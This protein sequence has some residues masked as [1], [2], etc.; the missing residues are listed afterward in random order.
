MTSSNDDSELSQVSKNISN[1]FSI[2]AGSAVPS[3]PANHTRN[4]GT[5]RGIQ[6]PKRPKKRRITQ[7]PT[8]Q[9]LHDHLA[10]ATIPI[11]ALETSYQEAEA[12]EDSS[13][14]EDSTPQSHTPAPGSS[15]SQASES[16]RLTRPKTSG[17]HQH[18]TVRNSR[19]YCNRCPK[20]YSITGGTANMARHLKKQHAIDLATSA[21]AEKRIREG[22]TIDMAI[23][24]GAEANIKANEQR[25]REMMGI[26]LD[27]A[28][29][30]Y[31][32]LQWTISHDVAFNQVRDT[33]FRT[34]L[35][36]VN[37]V[38]NRMLPDSDS[39]IKTHAEGLFAE[40]KQRLRHILATALSDIHITCDMWTSPNHLG[41]LAVIAHFTSE[42]PEHCTV[43]LALK[44]L[45]GE[46]SGENQAGVVL[47]VLNDYEIRNKL[48][49]MVMDNVGSNDTLIN[50]VATSLNNEGVAYDVN[51][52]RLRCNGHVIN[53]AVQAFLFGKA[54][55]DYEY[56]GNE[57]ESPS[58]I[59]LS[60][61][62]RLGPLGKLHN[63]NVW[64]MRSPQRVQAFKNR[65][66]GLMPR[67]DN[68]TRWNSWYEM[69]DWSIKRLKPAIIAVTNE[70]SDLAKDLLTAEEWKT[71]DY[72]RDFLQNFYD[73][74]KATEGHGAT[75][76]EVLSTLDFLADIF[77]DAIVEF[78]DHAFMWESLQAGFTKL[79]KY[80]NKTDRSPAY[81]A[82]IVLDPTVK[83]QHF[84]TWD[85]QWRPDMRSTMKQF[86]ETQYRSST[87]LSS[88]SPTTQVSSTAKT[89][90]K[91]FEWK[92]R[93]RRL[94]STANSQ[95]A[96][97]DDEYSRYC[98][99][100][101]LVL[102]EE[103]VT[104]LDYWLK[105]IQRSRLPLLSKMAI[106]IHS[107]PAMAAEPERVFSGA[108]H[109]I[110]DQRNSLKSTTIELLECLK[111]WFRLGV[112]TEQDLHA[113]VDNLDEEAAMEVLEAINQ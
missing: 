46:H 70:E 38:A 48:G 23:L 44:E 32:Y 108:K 88:Y 105:P 57:A 9:A 66:K 35:D 110:S 26:G 89:Q 19:F 37:P 16:L 72:I 25:R 82:A 69:L 3:R 77:E 84:D 55:N 76:K 98:N 52:R 22:T 80:W 93:Q 62:R 8:S 13:S 101:P 63:I 53:L 27:K 15:V 95:S 104:A 56:L 42:K 54:V 49:Y 85:P 73:A 64:I 79:L 60:Q 74:T 30:E 68:G 83:W 20:S 100:E 39:T 4:A 91:Y 81:I 102:E 96:F 71:L 78:A 75:L 34:F 1:P 47:D 90:N 99:S 103:G 111:S 67:R 36:Y 33:Y 5:R 29:L 59:Q 97:N 14:F 11:S 45:Q 50:A 61:W 17:I 40:G 2:A 12:S 112:F 21:T 24:R 65:S 87:G 41:L 106:D 92:E 28:T 18:A 109:T 86:W 31:L 94:Q 107:I 113:I 43:T 58:D 7:V 6:S 10:L 51:H